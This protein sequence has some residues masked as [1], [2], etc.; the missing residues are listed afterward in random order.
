MSGR[1]QVTPTLKPKWKCFNYTFH[2]QARI[3]KMENY[4]SN[5]VF[6][7]KIS[8]KTNYFKFSIENKSEIILKKSAAVIFFIQFKRMAGT[9]RV[10][11]QLVDEWHTY[12]L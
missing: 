5:K 1:R 11:V 2:V 6:S 8:I 4:F 3:F 10:N 12:V 9:N 7:K